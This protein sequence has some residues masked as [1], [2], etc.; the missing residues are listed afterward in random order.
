MTSA[1]SSRTAPVFT[2]LIK[3]LFGSPESEESAL[4]VNS[5]VVAPRGDAPS[6]KEIA[7]ALIRSMFHAPVS[8]SLPTATA[9]VATPPI[10]NPPPTAP[11]P[12]AVPEPSIVVSRPNASEVS[13]HAYPVIVTQQPQPSSKSPTSGREHGTIKSP[14]SNAE[15]ESVHASNTPTEIPHLTA[16]AAPPQPVSAD[17][18]ISQPP[19]ASPDLSSPLA[20]KGVPAL[21][22]EIPPV[23]APDVAS[24][25]LPG[26]AKIEPELID[27]LR[28][29]LFHAASTTL[30]SVARH[31][32]IEKTIQSKASAM[33]VLRSPSVDFKSPPVT[34]I[35]TMALPSELG[36]PSPH[37]PAVRQD[38]KN[39]TPV[40]V[41][42]AQASHRDE[43]L[44][45]HVPLAPR[46]PVISD[47][48]NLVATV[49]QSADAKSSSTK[50]SEVA[51]AARLTPFHPVETPEPVPEAEPVAPKETPAQNNDAAKPAAQPSAPAAKALGFPC[52]RQRL[53]LRTCPVERRT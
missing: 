27:K 17:I 11:A 49:K 37:E 28:R 46:L 20:M 30:P 33:P 13:P 22:L 15:K 52:S 6:P 35:P 23:V 31:T 47:K 14:I 21:A 18:P 8:E 1:T 50:L 25:L 48:E 9:R 53:R 45:G 16:A 40:R 29:D 3:M 5:S 32:P 43:V 24:N 4:A 36:L 42:V 34:P 26:F 44:S 39:S 10:P 12:K 41:G 2:G 38:H 19:E 51:F 7:S